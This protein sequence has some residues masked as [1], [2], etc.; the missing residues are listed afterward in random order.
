MSLLTLDVRVRDVLHVAGTTSSST[1]YEQHE[2]LDLV[3]GA[4]MAIIPG[5]GFPPKTLMREPYSVPFMMMSCTE[6]LAT[7]SVTPAYYMKYQVPSRLAA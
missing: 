5:S 4:N 7:M 2:Y 1:G 3:P 6:T